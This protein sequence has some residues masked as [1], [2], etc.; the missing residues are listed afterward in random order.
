MEPVQ[1]R[2]RG[3]GPALRAGVHGQGVGPVRPEAVV[4]MDSLQRTGAE[5]R[6]DEVRQRERSSVPGSR[7]RTTTSRIS[8]PELAGR[9]DGIHVSVSRPDTAHA[10][11]QR[12]ALPASGDLGH[13]S[14][15]RPQAGRPPTGLRRHPDL[16]PAG[17]RPRGRRLR[18]PGLPRLAVRIGVPEVAGRVQGDRQ[19]GG[20]GAGAAVD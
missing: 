11:K 6:K 15:P 2:R 1:H 20:S 17:L 5:K 13:R 4:T 8:V 16:S 10:T 18:D 9:Q 3:D 12:R 7:F 19:G 14:P